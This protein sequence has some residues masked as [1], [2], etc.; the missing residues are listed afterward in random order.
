MKNDKKRQ[1]QAIPPVD[2][3]AV[4]ND[5]QQLAPD[6]QQM[7]PQSAETPQS[8]Q[9]AMLQLAQ[10]RGRN[11]GTVNAFDVLG[12]RI[13]TEA[14]HKAN[15]ILAKYKE[16]KANLE[17]RIIDNEQWYKLRHWECMRDKGNEVE[18]TSAWLF[19]VIANKHADA[20]DSFPEPNILPREEGDKG[21]A[22]KLTSIVPVVLDQ[23][24]FEQVYSD[25]WNYKL[26]SGTGVYGVF[27]DGAANNG[28]GDIKIEK[29]DLLNLFWESGITDIQ[30]SHNLFHIELCDNDELLE[31]YPQLNGKLGG[32]SGQIAVAKYNYDDS[33]DTS[34]KSVMVDWYYRK[35]QNGKTV[36]HYCKYVNDVVLFA[37]ENEEEYRERG[38]YDHAEY[39][40]VFD[41]L[42][43]T[44]GTPTGYSYI[45][46][47]KNGQAYI[48]RGNQALMQNMIVNARPRYFVNSGGG[49]NEEEFAD[50]TKPFVHCD[51][52]L[53]ND[54]IQAVTVHPI[55]S[56]YLEMLNCKIDEMKETA[57]NRDVNSGSTSSGVTAASAISALQ[58][59]GSKMS[60][61]ASKSAYRAYRRIVIQVIELI[62]QFYD[63]PRQFRILGENGTQRFIQ[64]SNA[65]IQPQ[66]QEGIFGADMGFRTP[67][68]DIEVSASKATPYSK[69]A[70]NE[71]T[72]QLYQLGFFNPQ[73]ADQALLALDMMDFDRKEMLMQKISQNGTM[74]QQLMQM[75]QQ[76]MMLG[77]IVDG[78]KGGNEVTAGLA[79]QFGAQQQP[80]AQ[81]GQPVNLRTSGEK[82]GN[83]RAEK[84]RQRSAEATIPQ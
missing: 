59:A 71:L 70:Q 56:T 79:Q 38:W 27:W 5:G 57:G 68:F 54:S 83:S 13:G 84:A 23:C 67:L 40:F 72:I 64:Y 29:I 4:Q 8:E 31:T 20:M 17:R 45:D 55:S 77:Q 52:N 11:K 81:G 30:K 28:L 41:V 6:V 9:E 48:D 1:E 73:M 22:E 26:K 10:P 35:N 62:R 74:Y 82:Q 75:Q 14:I 51:S 3:P 65:G 58:E 78:M 42:F 80:E 2:N 43:Q 63:L 50:W 18:P 33:V 61:D 39:P 32:G 46:I 49:V 34:N 36:L 19:N 24:D 15:T 60:R 21:E 66:Q 25:V 12:G 44:E 69:L 76:L 37:T 53:G 47:C 7:P 16:G